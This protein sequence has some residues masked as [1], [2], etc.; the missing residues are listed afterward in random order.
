[1]ETSNEEISFDEVSVVSDW[2]NDLEDYTLD[3]WDDPTPE[4]LDKEKT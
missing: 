2:D 3:R 4:L 1:L